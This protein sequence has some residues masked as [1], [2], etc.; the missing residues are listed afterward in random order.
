MYC[1]PYSVGATMNSMK[2]SILALDPEKLQELSGGTIPETEIQRTF[3]HSLDGLKA[4]FGS[5]GPNLHLSPGICAL[6]KHAYEC[7]LA[8]DF[9]FDTSGGITTQI[10]GVSFYPLVRLILQ[11]LVGRIW[12]EPLDFNR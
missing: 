2:D 4:S 3:F 11:G 5:L 10:Q 12:K 6:L 1:I 7:I 8:R 9:V